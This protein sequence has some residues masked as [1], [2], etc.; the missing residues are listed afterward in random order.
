M[1]TC[2][3]W[4]HCAVRAWDLISLYSQLH[5]RDKISEVITFFS[6]LYTRYYTFR[7]KIY[8]SVVFR[9]GEP[10]KGHNNGISPQKNAV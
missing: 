7:L 2:G 4:C 8:T 5:T 9:Y 3:H 1:I 10:V 6:V